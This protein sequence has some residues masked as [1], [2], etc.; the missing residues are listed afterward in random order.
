MTSAEHYYFV[1]SVGF[2]KIEREETMIRRH[3]LMAFAIFSVLCAPTVVRSADVDDVKATFEQGVKTL[4]ALDVDGFMALEHDQGVRIGATSPFPVDG[5]AAQR[6][7]LQHVINNR[8]SQ[9][10]TPINPQ[11]R[12]IGTTGIAWGNASL[13]IKPK[14]GPL[15]TH[16]MR[17]TIVYAKSDGKWLRVASHLSWMP[18][19]N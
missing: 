12:V 19:G 9:T 16:Y 7:G 18:A 5:K 14:D 15:E 1:G 2:F 8:E 13:A 6:Q 3:T 17:Y 11:F 4:N 10:F